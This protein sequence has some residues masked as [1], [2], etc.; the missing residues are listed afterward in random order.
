MIKKSQSILERLATL[1][2]GAAA[3]FLALIALIITIQIIARLFG[4]QIPSSDDFAIW[5]M[6]ACMFLALPYTLL[7][8]DHIRITVFLQMLPEKAKKIY[9]LQATAISI[10]LGVWASY[11]TVVFVYESYL[12]NEISQGLVPVPLWIPQLPIPLGL[13][14]LTAVLLQRFMRIWHNAP[15]EDNNE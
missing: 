5:S 14:L 8:G 7:K 2:G 9:E 13:I 6:V 4:V 11:Y 10:A 12:Y 1:S 3:V 15:L